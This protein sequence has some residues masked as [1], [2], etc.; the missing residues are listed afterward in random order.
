MKAKGILFFT[1]LLGLIIYYTFLLHPPWIIPTLAV[2]FS[3]LGLIFI[4]FEKNHATTRTIS[5]L[6]FITALTVVSRQIIHGVAVS[7]VFLFTIITGYLF[8]SVSGFMVGAA[9]MLVSN[10]FVGGQ[11][12]WT[13]FQM[14]GLGL[15]GAAASILPKTPNMKPKIF[16]LSAYG[17]AS[18][19]LYSAVTDIFWW[20]AFTSKHTLATYLAISAA[21]VVFSIARGLGN[22]LLFI[23]LGP[24]ILKVLERF[25]DRFYVEYL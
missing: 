22:I 25:R 15:V 20:M 1:T 3:I 17:L 2:V 14:I 12:P 23:L 7:P 9:S 4:E 16:I 8:G 6:G 21:G 5:L 10:F 18:S 19:F 24:P 11:G 13:P